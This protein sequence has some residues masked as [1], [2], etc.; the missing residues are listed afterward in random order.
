MPY[1]PPGFWIRLVSRL[2]ADLQM[3]D[4]K[5]K[6]STSGNERKIYSSKRL[7]SSHNNKQWELIHERLK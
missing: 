2:I 5:K 1:L 7:E 4:K 3:R 6:T